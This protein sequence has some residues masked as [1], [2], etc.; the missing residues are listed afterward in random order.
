MSTPIRVPADPASSHRAVENLIARYAELVDDGDF[1]GLGDLLADAT[2]IG[3]GEPV[4]GSDAIEKMFQ[5]TVIIHADGTPRTQHVTTNVAIEVDEAAGT[6]I[7]RSYITVLQALPGFPLQPIGGG[8]YHDRFERREGRWR[9]AER[10]V[11][12]THV[13]DTSHH[14]RRAVA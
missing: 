2:F 14:L 4:S 1:A 12:I 3:T 8:R 10:R 13:G 9:F 11:R 7:S 6:A 5:D